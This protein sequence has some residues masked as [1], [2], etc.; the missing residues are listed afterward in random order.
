MF[1]SR[2]WIFGIVDMCLLSAAVACTSEPQ[3]LHAS[4]IAALARYALDRESKTAWPCLIADGHCPG[5]E[6]FQPCLLSARPCEADAYAQWAVDQRPLRLT[7][8]GAGR[9]R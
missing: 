4:P 2:A 9:D 1:T 5:I 6:E 3:S 7:T 8:V